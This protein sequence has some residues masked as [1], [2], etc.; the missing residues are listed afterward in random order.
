MGGIISRDSP[1]FNDYISFY[2][3]SNAFYIL[4]KCDIKLALYSLNS[5][6]DFT[7]FVFSFYTL[8]IKLVLSSSAALLVLV[9]VLIFLLKKSR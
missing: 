4:D 7:K 5:L 6:H 3:I 8:I 9:I 1:L 2:N